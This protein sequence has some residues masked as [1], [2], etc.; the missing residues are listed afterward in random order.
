MNE[1][2]TKPAAACK[3]NTRVDLSV[4][5]PVYNEQSVLPEMHRRLTKSLEALSLVSEIVY[6]NDGSGDASSALLRSFTEG[7]GVVHVLHL[8]RNFGKEAATTAGIDY[9][10]GDAVVILDADLQDPP[11]L[12]GEMVAQWE[13]G[14]DC[15]LMRRRSRAG[16][17]WLKKATSASF[18]RVL[19]RISD[20]EMPE[21]VGDFRL[22]SRRAVD[23]LRRCTERTRYMGGLFAWLGFR[24][25]VLAYDRDVRFAGLTKWRYWRL[26]NLALEGITSFSTIP[27]KISSYV[28]LLT[29][30][31]AFAYL[32]WVLV[33]TAYVGDPVPGHA[34]TM[35]VTLFLGGIQL[36]GLGI[37]GEY[38]ARVFV[39]VK[40][41][42][43]YLVSDI[44]S[45]KGIE[46]RSPLSREHS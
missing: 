17:T 44:A 14:F 5:V 36:M 4:V 24:S 26:W 1:N 40:Q 2:T 32:V 45:S 9:S 42:P 46:P 12:I 10:H 18:H 15:V 16:E 7:H 8:S 21:G 28:G 11:E 25:V 38:L 6:V 41:R 39:E 43:L 27:L 35:V 29:A 31:A 13:Q 34:S 33:K 20:V 19:R 30:L 23:A 3:T 22:L 37:V